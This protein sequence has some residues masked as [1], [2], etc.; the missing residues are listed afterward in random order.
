MTQRRGARF[1]NKD[2]DRF[3]SESLMIKELGWEPL[4]ERRAK[5]KAMTAYKFSISSLTFNV[6]GSFSQ[7]LTTQ[8]VNQ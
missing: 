1:V 7:I 8:G 2:Y 3:A 4:I 5:A 6:K